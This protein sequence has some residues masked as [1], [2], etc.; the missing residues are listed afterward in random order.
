MARAVRRENELEGGSGPLLV[1]AEE[2]ASAAFAALAALD[3][4]SDEEGADEFALERFAKDV[5]RM[6]EERRRMGELMLPGALGVT[7]KQPPWWKGILIR[8]AI[9]LINYLQASQSHR[10]ALRLQR[11]HEQDFPP[12]PT[13]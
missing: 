2:G 6:V 7:A 12:T 13:F 3:E 9:L 10:A 8:G 11:Q 5:H 4:D 1:A